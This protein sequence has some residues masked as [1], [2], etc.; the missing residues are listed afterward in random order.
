AWMDDE[1]TLT[2]TGGVLG[3]PAY[4]SPEQILGRPVDR[5]S[6]LFAAAVSLYQL[7]S[8]R[9]PFEGKS[10][11]EMA[12]NVAYSEPAPLPPSVPHALARATLRGLQKSPAARYATATE[13]AAALRP[14][15]APPPRPLPDLAPGPAAV[16]P[17]DAPTATVV[18]AGSRCSRHPARPAAGLCQ[19]CRRPLCRACVRGDRPPYF[20][21]IHTP[22]TIFG[23]SAVRLEVALA[24]AAF[25]L[26]LLCLSPVGYAA[27]WR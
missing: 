1:A 17:A 3:S 24:L 16:L 23:I 25:L 18:D 27:L 13:F 11:M 5:R 20:C 9:L 10:L 7:L 22:V 8:D 12:H 19:A 26:L 14:P 21:R 6:D 15:A 4:M 2:R